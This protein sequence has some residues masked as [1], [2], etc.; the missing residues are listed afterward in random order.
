MS[1]DFNADPICEM[2][3]ARQATMFGTKL[4]GDGRSRK[5]VFCCDGHPEVQSSIPFERFFLKFFVHCGFACTHPWE[6]VE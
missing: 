5:W 2:C 3:R 4:V 6:V 1:L